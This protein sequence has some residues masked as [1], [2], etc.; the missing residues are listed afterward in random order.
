MTER[1]PQDI[2]AAAKLLA[3]WIGYAWDGLR[4]GRI[5]SYPQWS[6]NQVMGRMFQGRKQDLRD[7]ALKIAATVNGEQA[8]TG[9]G[10]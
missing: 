3:E 6:H 5:E 2:D 4:E 1:R 7:L 8:T 9:G 10:G